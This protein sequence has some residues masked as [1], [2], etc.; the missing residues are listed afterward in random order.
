MEKRSRKSQSAASHQLLQLGHGGY[1]EGSVAVPF[2]A[3]VAYE[4]QFPEVNVA[5]QA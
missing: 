3:G 4:V 1:N 5:G 2:C